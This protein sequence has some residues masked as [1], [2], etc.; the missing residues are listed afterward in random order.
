MVQF[1]RQALVFFFFFRKNLEIN[2]QQVNLLLR[3]ESLPFRGLGISTK[4]IQNY[5][6]VSLQ[7]SGFHV[8]LNDILI[9]F[10]G[11]KCLS[12]LPLTADVELPS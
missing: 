7:N 3:R 11:G 6:S 9:F 2:V 1:L 10:L 4:Y 8:Y 12:P 5:A